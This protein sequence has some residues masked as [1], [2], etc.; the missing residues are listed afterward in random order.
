MEI[1]VCI[2]VVAEESSP[3]AGGSW[4]W[5]V[6]VGRDFADAGSCLNAGVAE[7]EWEAT[8]VGQAVGVAAAKVAE[9][10]GRLELT[11]LPTTVILDHDPCGEPWPMLKV[12]EY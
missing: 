3:G 12:E 1:V 4:R 9:R 6:H 2:H 10:C 7:T 5:A 11:D 8:L